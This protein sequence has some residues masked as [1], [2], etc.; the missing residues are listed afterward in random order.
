MLCTA[1]GPCSHPLVIFQPTTT[2]SLTSHRQARTIGS[3]RAQ[4]F[5][6][7][8]VRL[9]GLFLTLLYLHLTSPREG[10]GESVRTAKV[11]RQP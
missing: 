2:T 8:L 5:C 11:R 4:C 1:A 10:R 3:V 7:A 9:F 6:N